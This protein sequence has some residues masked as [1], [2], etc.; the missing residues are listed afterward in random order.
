MIVQEVRAV[1]ALKKNEKLINMLF[2]SVMATLEPPKYT[3]G[4]EAISL[5]LSR[6][7][8]GLQLLLCIFWF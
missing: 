8:K 2:A 1:V 6:S 7:R 5:L 4:E 3:L